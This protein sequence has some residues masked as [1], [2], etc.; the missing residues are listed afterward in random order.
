MQPNHRDNCCIKRLSSGDINIRLW[1][2][3]NLQKRYSP[4]GTLTISPAKRRPSDLD[5]TALAGCAAGGLGVGGRLSMGACHPQSVPHLAPADIGTADSLPLQ[6]AATARAH[7]ILRLPSPRR[8]KTPAHGAVDGRASGLRLYG[9]LMGI[10][11]PSCCFCCVPASCN[12]LP[13]IDEQ[14]TIGDSAGALSP[15][16]SSPGSLRT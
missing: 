2:R 9:S 10:G 6:Q 16:R 11:L 1:K 8:I 14:A 5:S 7:C 12:T 3:S 15:V 4:T 13:R